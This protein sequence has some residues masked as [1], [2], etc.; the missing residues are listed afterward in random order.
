MDLIKK[1]SNYFVDARYKKALNHINGYEQ[2]D[3]WLTE[4]EAFGLYHIASILAEDSF[5]VEIGSWKGKST[6][7]IAKG[8]NKG[9]IYA[10]DPFNA[11]GEEGSK[12]IYE[13][14]KGSEPLYDQFISNMTSLGVI[15]KIQ[16]LKGYS[17]QFID[18][19]E[20]IDF[21]FIDGDHSIAGCE[22]DFVNFSP[23]VKVGGYVALHDFDP[24]RLDLGPTWVVNNKIL[25]NNGFQFY[26]QFDSLWVAKKIKDN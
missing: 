9:K 17:S 19:V 21:L 12:E 3:G 24:D 8:L 7:C 13:L 2:I 23:K 20:T 16:P 5:V 10:I 18:T 11:E 15:N 25:Q 22:Y 1:I 26:N 4:N 14:T 6:F